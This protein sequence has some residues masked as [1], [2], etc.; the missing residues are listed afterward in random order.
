MSDRVL[1]VG[2]NGVLG[3]ALV[4]TL[5]SNYLVQVFAADIQPESVSGSDVEY[6]QV[7]GLDRVAVSD[8]VAAKHPDYIVNAAGSFSN[9]FE[10]DLAVNTR[11][12]V[13]ICHAVDKNKLSRQTR[14]VLIGSAAEY[15][16]SASGKKLISEGVPCEPSS[17][18]GLSKT[19]QYEIALFYHRKFGLDIVIARVFNILARALSPKLLIGRLYDQIDRIKSGDIEQIKLGYLY[20]YRDYLPVETIVE[21]LVR[22]MRTGKSGEVY[23]VGSGIP[24]L[25]ADLVRK[26]LTEEGLS[27]DLVVSSVPK[28]KREPTCFVSDI[29]KLRRLYEG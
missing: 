19:L 10:V 8:L 28:D 5:S 1:V 13:N 17:V 21:H 27:S 29:T 7:D 23:N 15:G 16:E 14:I 6:A 2:A 11:L 4:G 22:I 18:Y 24:I 12:P 9:D 3:R 25:I 20:D 26:I